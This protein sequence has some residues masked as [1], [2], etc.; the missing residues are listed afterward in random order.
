MHI[1]KIYKI[2]NELLKV[3]FKPPP[4]EYKYTKRLKKILN[5][6]ER[7]YPLLLCKPHINTLCSFMFKGEMYR[8]LIYDEVSDLRETAQLFSEY[9]KE[10]ALEITNHGTLPMNDVL[11]KCCAEYYERL[12]HKR[13]NTVED[14]LRSWR[15]GFLI[16]ISAYFIFEGENEPANKE[17]GK[18]GRI[19]KIKHSSLKK[20]D[21]IAVN[22]PDLSAQLT[23]SALTRVLVEYENKRDLLRFETRLKGFNPFYSKMSYVTR[24]VMPTSDALAV[25]WWLKSADEREL[26]NMWGTIFS[27]SSINIHTQKKINLIL[28]EIHKDKEE[29]LSDFTLGGIVGLKIPISVGLTVISSLASI[30]GISH[31]IDNVL[32]DLSRN[33]PNLHYKLIAH[34]RGTEQQRDIIRRDGDALRNIRLNHQDLRTEQ[35]YRWMYLQRLRKII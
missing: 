24:Q 23:I 16:F 5:N 19:A 7:A 8:N 22:N 4:F 28:S 15:W 20:L 29:L 27:G 9:L 13:E 17:N 31:K 32:Y 25:L 33:L 2:S 6:Y 12:R 18:N 35:D 11:I 30:Y 14:H 26:H 10:T 34:V 21:I 3:L 1:P